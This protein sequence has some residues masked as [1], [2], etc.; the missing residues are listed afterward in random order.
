MLSLLWLPPPPSSPV[1]PK[2]AALLLPSFVQTAVPDPVREAKQVR[3]KCDGRN[4]TQTSTTYHKFVMSYSFEG[5]ANTRHRDQTTIREVFENYKPEFLGQW[6]RKP[7]IRIRF[8]NPCD[9]C[10]VMLFFFRCVHTSYPVRFH[11]FLDYSLYPRFSSLLC[12]FPLLF[13]QLKSFFCVE[14]VPR[15]ASLPQESRDFVFHHTLCHLFTT[16]TIKQVRVNTVVKLGRHSLKPFA[17]AAILPRLYSDKKGKWKAGLC[18][19]CPSPPKKH[20]HLCAECRSKARV[21]FEVGGG[22]KPTFSSICLTAS[23]LFCCSSG[24]TDSRGEHMVAKSSLERFTGQ[25][26]ASEATV[27][28]KG[29]ARKAKTP[30]NLHSSFDIEWPNTTTLFGLGFP[31]STTTMTTWW[32]WGS[33][34]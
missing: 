13:K 32:C 15:C 18:A 19:V 25:G 12:F 9:D 6:F 21:S 34:V 16:N 29:L 8:T 10:S 3:R 17:P 33:I 14:L 26:L 1:P 20:L 22:R 27:D 5:L 7:I 30:K 2:R 28:L 4:T 31:L 24:A 23:L 11:S